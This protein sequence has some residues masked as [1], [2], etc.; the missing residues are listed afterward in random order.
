MKYGCIVLEKNAYVTIKRL[1]SLSENYK[2]DTRKY[3]I[4]RLSDELKTAQI[5]NREEL[6]QDV[7]R[8]NSL[9]TVSTKDNSW[10]TTFQLVLPTET[11]AALKKVSVLAPMG[12][13]VIGY[14]IGDE[15]EW[16]F[17]AGVKT[18]IIK[19]VSQN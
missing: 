15:I 2:V 7:I 4:K 1:L 18:L 6:P 12:A 3:S 14:A 19:D 9:I 10:E 16:E 17:P 13:A 5:V 8:F 11:N